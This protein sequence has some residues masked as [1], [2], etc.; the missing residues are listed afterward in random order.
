MKKRKPLLSP[1]R[2]LQIAADARRGE[3]PALKA[4]YDTYAKAMKAYKANPSP[5]LHLD[6]VLKGQ[7]YWNAV[8]AHP[9]YPKGEQHEE[10]TD[11]PVDGA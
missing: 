4:L 6:A 9:T 11:V 2:T 3:E 8:K 7:V 10:A 1:F 5:R